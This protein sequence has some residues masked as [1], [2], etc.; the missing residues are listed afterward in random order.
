MFFDH[1]RVGPEF[2]RRRAQAGFSL[3]EL[4]VVLA[5]IGAI[6]AMTIPLVNEQVRIAEIRSITDEIAVHLRAA[7]MIAVSHH[8]DIVVTVSVDPTNTISYEGTNGDTRLIT[9]PGRVKIKSGSSVSIT[10]HSDG[11]TGSTSTL[12]TEST[13]SQ[14]IER[15]TLSINTVG[16]ITVAHVRV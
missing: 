8:K 11:S 4:L 1:P 9:M 10:F 2:R 14:A 15:W 5:I 12:T 7:R 3:A 6:V 13:V 16:L